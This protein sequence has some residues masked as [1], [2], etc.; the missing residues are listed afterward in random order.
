MANFLG[1]CLY[2]YIV[3][4]PQPHPRHQNPCGL[5]EERYWAKREL[6]L[7]CS[8]NKGSRCCW[9]RSEF[10]VILHKCPMMGWRVQAIMSLPQ[11]VIV[12]NI[13]GP[14][15]G[16][17]LWKRLLYVIEILSAGSAPRSWE[18]NSFT[19]AGRSGR[20]VTVSTTLRYM[21]RTWSQMLGWGP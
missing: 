18:N 14:G 20:S 1:R 15:K 12:Y 6:G 13:S 5:W 4:F 10:G 7:W 17:W 9:R 2:F 8:V 19:H 11:P 16:M 3:P 21:V